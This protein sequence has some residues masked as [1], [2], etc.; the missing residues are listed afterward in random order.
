MNIYENPLLTNHH[1]GISMTR[2]E[3]AR[4]L[5]ENL[6][7][8]SLAAANEVINKFTE[9]MTEAMKAGE[10]VTLP[11]LGKFVVVEKAERTCRNPRT[12]ETMK[13]PAKK[14]IK[15]KAST[16]IKKIVNE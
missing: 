14:A 5:K 4:K 7:L 15:F 3:F 9:V 2:D 11:A 13:V 6:N 16:N 1:K 12:G 10:E 8:N